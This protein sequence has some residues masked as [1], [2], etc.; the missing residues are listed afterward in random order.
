MIRKIH[1]WIGVIGLILFL[2]SGQYFKHALGG[3]QGLENTPRLLLRTSHVYL[4]LTSIINLVF[5]LYYVQP[6]KIRWF[7]I[8][9]QSLIMLAPFFV[10]YSFV[11]ET[12]TNTGINRPFTLIGMVLILAWVGNIIIG[13]LYSFFK[14]K[15]ALKARR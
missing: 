9:N 5:G 1:L 7:T 12:I 4:F 11:F 15:Q 14:C 10:G 2:L 6:E 8:Y 13:K 3:L